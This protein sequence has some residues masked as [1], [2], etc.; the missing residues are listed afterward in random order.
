M[1][2][3]E[4][5]IDNPLNE[6]EDSSSEDEVGGVFSAD[7]DDSDNDSFPSDDSDMSDDSDSDDSDDSD[8]D[9]SMDDDDD[10]D[11]E[12]EEAESSEEAG[13]SAK[14]LKKDEGAGEDEEEE[15]PVVQAILRNKDKK[16]ER[17]PDVTVEEL[18]TDIS[19]HPAADIIATGNNAGDIILYKYSTESVDVVK[20]YEIHT[21]ACRAVEFNADGDTIFSASKDKSISLT[22]SESGKL[23]QLYEKAHEDEIY[24]LSVLRENII[25]TGDQSGVLKVWDIRTK[26]ELFSIKEL[27]DYISSIKGKEDSN[28]IAYTSGEGVVTAVN[29]NTKKLDC[30]TNAIEAELTCSGLFRNETKYVVGSSLG[31][32]YIYD[33]GNFEEHT[34]ILNPSCEKKKTGPS[35]SCLLPISENVVLTGLDNGVIRATHMFPSQHLGIV[36]QHE[37]AVDSLDISYDGQYVASSSADLK[38]RFWPI[39]YFQDIEISHKDKATKAKKNFNLPSSKAVNPSNFFSGLM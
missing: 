30:Q 31:V 21:K 14:R 15:D 17:P 36:G 16:R 7:S 32:L 34:D 8:E 23:K 20:T 1:V 29:F 26:S 2:L 5:F 24:C 28:I 3:S 11:G 10:E 38:L 33:W 12:E 37:L 35:I 18:I 39:A 6:G 27:D 4:H 9:D 22:D 19:F 13:P 25:A